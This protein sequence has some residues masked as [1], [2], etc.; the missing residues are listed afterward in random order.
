MSNF[1]LKKIPLLMFLSTFPIY[2]FAGSGQTV[3]QYEHN[4]KSMDRIHGDTIKLIHKTDNNWQYEFK[5]GVTEGGGNK[6]D[7]LYDDMHGGSGG[8]VIQKNITLDNGWGSIIPALE[9]GF[10]KDLVLYQPGLKYSYKFNSDWSSSIRYR[11]EWKKISQAERYKTA[12]VSGQQVKYKATSNSGRHRFDWALNYSGFKA[13]NLAYTFNYY[14]GDFTNNSYKFSKGTFEKNKYI[15]YNNKK[16]DYEQE[17]KITYNY[18]KLLRPYFSISDVS[19]NKTTDTRQAKFKVGFNY[20]FGQ[21]NSKDS[22]FSYKTYFKYAHHYG[23]SSHYHGDSFGLYAD[24]DKKGYI[25]LSLNTYNQ[26][27]NRILFDDLVSSHYQIYGGYNFYLADQWVLTPNIEVRFYSGG[28]YKA[29][30]V[31]NLPHYQL[32][33]VSDSQRPGVRYSP[34]LKLTWLQS[35]DVSFYSQYRFEYRKVS[36]SKREDSVQGYVDNRSRNRFDVGTDI[37]L[38]PDWNIGYRFS[39]LKGNYVLQND[40]RHDYQQELDINWQ[41]TKAWQVNFAAEDVA[42]RVHSDSRETKLAL[43]LSY[44]F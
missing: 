7:V 33:D 42:K 5:F 35:D 20:A 13:F 12:K 1:K 40:K 16:N 28:G 15:A 22:D 39:Y 37:N 31:E 19:K 23:L 26:I 24:F 17:F 38:S 36:R 21:S 43:G 27:K 41:V 25:G 8:V 29:K 10:S 3:F 4:W 9:L 2:S 6:R 11:Y 18:S 30:S 34:A 14:L 44:L 32:G